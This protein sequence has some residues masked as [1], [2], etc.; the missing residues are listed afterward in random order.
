MNQSARHEFRDVIVGLCVSVTLIVVL[1]F[2]FGPSPLGGSDTYQIDASFQRV[3]GLEVGS[4][5]Q[6]AGVTVGRVSALELSDGFRVRTRME[7]DAGIELDTDASAAIVTDG[8]FGGKLINIDIG[9]GENTIQ[10]GGSISFTEDA[11]ILDDLFQLII[12]QARANRDTNPSES[13]Q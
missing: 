3:D 12:A 8:I 10:D 2:V 11:V 1:F 5:V 13:G 7:I 9:G 4:P 6:A